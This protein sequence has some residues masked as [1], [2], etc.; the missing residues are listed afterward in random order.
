[1]PTVPIPAAMPV[2]RPGPLWRVLQFPLT[3]IVVA[4]IPLIVVMVLTE[5]AIVSR[6]LAPAVLASSL[7]V[8]L[9]GVISA[10]IYAGCVRL[11]EQ[12]PLIELGRAGMLRELAAGTALGLALFLVVA[13]LLVALGFGAIE[14]GDGV[15][16]LL[17]SLLWV[18]GTAI[19][20]EILFRGV[21]FRILEERLGTWLALALSAL[22]FGGLHA[23]NQNA[24]AASTLAIALEAG[25]LLAAAYVAT[26]RLWLPIALHAGWNLAQLGILGVQRPGH[27][28]HGLW[29]STYDG[30]PLLTGGAW[31]PEISIFAI[32]AC[33]LASLL[34]L[35]RAH[36]RGHLVRPYWSR[37]SR[38][39]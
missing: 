29:S 27:V 13:G 20:E 4:A 30:P 1:M 32:L 21:L 16:V 39:T 22:L 2:R 5:Q 12:R 14:P 17:P 3:R 24:S 28:T 7:L 34:L 11:L 33:L 26:R 37:A 19:S 15:Q 36:R 10:A 9:G 6:G 31:G 38:S 23:T 8:V 25:V 35:A 18:I